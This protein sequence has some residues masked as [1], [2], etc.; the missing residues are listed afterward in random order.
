MLTGPVG[1]LILLGV[2]LAFAL[3]VFVVAVSQTLR[4]NAMASQR[5]ALI[6]ATTQ[7][8]DEEKGVLDYCAGVEQAIAPLCQ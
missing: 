2:L 1:P 7:I 8:P 4:M 5:E 6:D 3:G